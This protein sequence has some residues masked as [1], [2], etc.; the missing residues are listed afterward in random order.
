M[1]DTVSQWRWMKGCLEAL[2][3]GSTDTRDEQSLLIGRVAKYS[4]YVHISQ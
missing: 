2:I 4:C 1:D 3:G